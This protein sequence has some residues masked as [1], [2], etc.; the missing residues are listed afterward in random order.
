LQL[1]AGSDGG[2]K[3]DMAAS[4]E[5]SGRIAT[6]GAGMIHKKARAVFDDFVRRL[7]AEGA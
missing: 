1:A 4:Y 2:S 7:T 5:V 6:L 3:V